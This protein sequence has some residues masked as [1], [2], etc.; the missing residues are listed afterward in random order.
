ME[1]RQGLGT[2]AVGARSRPRRR[3]AG[4]DHDRHRCLRPHLDARS[5]PVSAGCPGQGG[6]RA[7]RRG[8]DSGGVH[9]RGVRAAHAAGDDV[10]AAARRR[11]GGVRRP[12][13]RGHPALPRGPSGRRRQTSMLSA[14]ASRHD[15]PRARVH[16]RRLRGDPRVRRSGQARSAP[17]PGDGSTTGCSPTCRRASTRAARTA[18]STRSSTPVRSCRRR[19]PS[20]SARPSSATG[21]CSPT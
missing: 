7:T 14:V 19:S 6:R 11:R 9:E 4:V 15:E 18:S 12:V 1:W 17:L 3:A 8:R 16:R 21:S 10:R 13:H 2:G 20:R 5:P